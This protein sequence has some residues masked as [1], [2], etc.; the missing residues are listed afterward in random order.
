MAHTDHA[1]A[2]APS[3]PLSSDPRNDP[4]Q[5]PDG[6]YSAAELAICRLELLAGVSPVWAE[7]EPTL[8]ASRSAEVDLD[9]IRE[10]N[11]GKKKQKATGSGP[12][13][14]G[15]GYGHSGTEGGAQWDVAATEKAQAQ[16][17]IEMRQMLEHVTEC[18][19]HGELATET[20]QQ[21]CLRPLLWRQLHTASLLDVGSRPERT[22][23]YKQMLALLRALAA[24]PAL[25][26]L[27]ATPAGKGM[28]SD[29]SVLTALES[30]RKQAEFFH[31]TTGRSAST[32][33]EVDAEL[34]STRQLAEAIVQTA[35]EVAECA[36][37]PPTPAPP[38]PPATAPSTRAEAAARA[39]TPRTTRQAAAAAAAAAA[40][41]TA[42]KATASG[43]SAQAKAGSATDG[44]KSGAGASRGEPESAAEADARYEA[45]MREISFEAC[46][47]LP[48]HHY[49]K[50][51]EGREAAATQL[52]ARTKR[53]TLEAAD[54]MGG[55]LPVSASSSIWVRIHETSMQLWRAM[56]SG[57]E[58]T[59]YSGGLFTFDILAPSD[60]PN[61]A[62]N[63][64]LQTTGGGSVRFNPN[65]YNCGKVCLSLLGTWQG[66]QG[67]SWHA[68]T[69]TLLQV[70]MSIQALILVPD[71]FFN[72]P[73]YERNR[74]TP[75]GDRQSRAYNE[76]IREATVRYA[77]ISQLRSP[78]PELK[79]AIHSHFRMRRRQIV[80]QVQGWAADAGN[81]SRHAETMRGLVRELEATITSSLAD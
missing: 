76:V 40:N 19:V 7:S 66:D 45:T 4:K 49:E 46:D 31:R 65:L 3:S 56:I 80:E 51:A 32:S 11:F 53:L 16:A 20:L 28:S 21:S 52:A 14:S 60:Y 15:V 81:S 12:W 62:P 41:P 36:K 39:G 38:P 22:S 8:L 17:D 73:G 42:H 78:P 59:P 77:M 10:L 64:N 63:V 30:V 37:A 69:S 57:P 74:G 23:M 18:A 5:H 79:E 1:C 34:L 6:A 55:A 54:M 67:E 58:G 2:T 61:V 71:P 72:E 47:N 9:R 29:V 13:E 25:Q 26:P 75:E 68:K 33:G 44:G 50:R 24:W 35:A 70:L 48:G 27:L 43:A